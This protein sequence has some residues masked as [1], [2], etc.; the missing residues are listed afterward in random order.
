MTNVDKLIVDTFARL[1]I[2]PGAPEGPIGAGLAALAD[3]QRRTELFRQ[4]REQVAAML[5]V[6]KTAP[7]NPYATDEAIAGAIL[8]RVE[9]RRKEMEGRRKESRKRC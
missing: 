7:D 2:P 4:A 5:A 9:E 8:A 1:A 3:N 6:V